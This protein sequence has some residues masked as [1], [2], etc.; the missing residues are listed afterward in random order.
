MTGHGDGLEGSYPHQGSE[1]KG[2]LS[3]ASRHGHDVIPLMKPFNLGKFD[4]PHR[5]VYAPLTRCR[6]LGGVPQSAA[7]E[8][9]SQ[10]ATG[11]LMLTEATCVAIEAHGYPNVPG[12]YTQEQI[13][14]WKPIVKAVHNKK[15]PFFLQ[16]WHTGRASSVDYQPGGKPMPSSTSKP[17]PGK[18]YT[19]FTPDGSK[20]AAFE[21]LPPP[22]AVAIS[23]IPG[24]V[25]L[26][27]VGARNS[28]KAGFDGV[29]I[30]GAHGYLID[31]FLKE[32]INDRTDEYGGSIENR[33][34]FCIEVVKAVVDEVGSDVV[35]IRL[36]PFTEFY[37]AYESDPY[38]LYN[39]LLKELNKFNLLYVHMVEPRIGRTMNVIE[40]D[41]S[42]KSLKTFKKLS[43]AA[44][45]AAGGYDRE[46][47]IVAIESGHTDLVCYGRPWIANPDLPRRYELDAPITKY[48][49]STFYSPD[50]VKGYTDYPFLPEDY[51]TNQ[52][53]QDNGNVENG[54]VNGRAE[55]GAAHGIVNGASPADQ[56]TAGAS[57]VLDKVKKMTVG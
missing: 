24:L 27:R 2:T 21:D 34:R 41:S 37:G 30:H 31:Q 13:E 7:A 20:Q 43:N 48:D 8:Y 1:L 9:Y 15:S 50:Q 45:I 46:N 55:N 53:G 57:A 40:V 19:I 42:K 49:R 29:E 6:A 36:S 10:R 47:G 17:I 16:L 5:M 32:S 56:V 54:T 35:G 39:Y 28:M 22:R 51:E 25:D 3:Q 4:L 52:K 44:F 12:I 18:E 14:A 33:C 26:Y 23:E 11:G 38:P